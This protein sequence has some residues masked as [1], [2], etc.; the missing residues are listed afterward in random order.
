MNAFDVHIY[1]IRAAATIVARKRA[2]FRDA[3]GYAVELGLL[4]ANPVSQVRWAAPIP[5]RRPP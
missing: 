4:P 2:V 5:A 1:T 3:A